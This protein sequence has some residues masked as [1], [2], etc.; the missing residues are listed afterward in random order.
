MI[1]CITSIH[2]FHMD[3][4]ELLPK[5]SENHFADKPLDFE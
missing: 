5:I 3:Y 1:F 4:R 2:S